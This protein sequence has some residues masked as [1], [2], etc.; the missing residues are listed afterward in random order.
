MPTTPDPPDESEPRQ[1]STRLN[2]DERIQVLTLR[3]AGFTYQQ[4][5]AVRDWDK[6][7]S[8]SPLL[9]LFRNSYFGGYMTREEYLEAR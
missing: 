1:N 5:T 9:S 4:I 2:R 8:R 6:I 7:S 3:D